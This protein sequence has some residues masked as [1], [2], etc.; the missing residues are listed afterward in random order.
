MTR[1]WTPHETLPDGT[2]RLH[3]K[4]CCENCGREIGDVTPEELEAAIAGAPLPAVADECGCPP[5]I[6]QLAMFMQGRDAHENGKWADGL[7][8]PTWEEIGPAGQEAYV[9]DATALLRAIV[10]LGWAPRTNAS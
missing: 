3:V 2:R 8:H 4:R 5:T 6:A 9:K 10:H 1:P 7:T